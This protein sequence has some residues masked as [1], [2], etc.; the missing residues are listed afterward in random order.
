M[1]DFN[2]LIDR[3]PFEPDTPALISAIKGK[4]VLITGGGGSIGSELAMLVVGYEPKRLVLAD[5]CEEHLFNIGQRLEIEGKANNVVLTI[6]DICNEKATLELFSKHKPDIV[7]HSAAYKHVPLME[8]HESE[9]R[10]N[11]FNGTVNV[12][13]A[14]LGARVG[15]TVM[16]ST[17][18]AVNPTSIMGKTKREAEVFV[19]TRITYPYYPPS[20]PQADVAIV[21]FGNVLGSSGS[22][23]TIWD[24]QVEAGKPITVT[25]PNMT[26]YFITLSEAAMLVLHTIT[27]EGDGD[28]FLLDMGEQ[29]NM[30]NLAK[31][32]IE[33]TGCKNDITIVGARGG[34][35][36]HEETHYSN[37][38]KTET[39]YSKIWRL[40]RANTR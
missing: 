7:F 15:K 23:L 26:R 14:S 5:R 24:R 4:T 21:R 18:K 3:E 20:L 31:R 32:Y 12:L 33:L 2:K 19:Q 22:V 25:D 16:I 8:N 40:K 37:E 6:T 38:K 11:N 27:M 34:E 1:V 30:M 28:I 10:D 29:I 17:D 36:M 35:K 39:K 9:A 13:G